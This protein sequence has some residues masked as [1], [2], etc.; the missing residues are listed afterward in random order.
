MIDDN[1]VIDLIVKDYT[2]NKF[3]NFIIPD[4]EFNDITINIEI[5]RHVNWDTFVI[6]FWI[7]NYLD[8]SNEYDTMLLNVIDDE[9]EVLK[10]INTI[11]SFLLHDFRDT[12]CYSKLIDK[13]YPI[14]VIKEKERLT[15]AYTK[16]CK[17]KLPDT[18]CVCMD[19]NKVI[20]KCNHNLCRICYKKLKTIIIETTYEDDLE[21][22]ECPLCRRAI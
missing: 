10:N 7:L 11:I 2:E 12:Y 1:D 13:I 5:M 15:M 3:K 18:C 22:K 8:K 14:K 19:Y 6:R 4:Y 17:K 20:T 9:K 16:L 21:C